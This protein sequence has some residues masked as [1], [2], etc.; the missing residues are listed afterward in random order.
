MSG[1]DTVVYVGDAAMFVGDAAIYGGKVAIYQA[2]TPCGADSGTVYAANAPFMEAIMPLMQAISFKEAKLTGTLARA[3]NVS[4][5]TPRSTPLSAMR[6]LCAAR[7]WCYRP[8]R[9]CWAL[10]GTER[11]YAASSTPMVSYDPNALRNFGGEVRYLPTHLIRDAWCRPSVWS[12]A[13]RRRA[14]YAMSGTELAYHAPLSVRG[15]RYCACYAV[16]GTE[17]AYAA[18]RRK[19]RPARAG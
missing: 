11:A 1:R 13:I 18:T 16:C 9:R 10:C 12:S 14:C 2:N 7:V 15:V 6:V 5:T 3:G 17:V 4:D 19:A 8:T